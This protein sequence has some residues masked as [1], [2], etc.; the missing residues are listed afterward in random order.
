[1]RA[2]MPMWRGDSFERLLCS[3]LDVGE[4]PIAEI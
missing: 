1:V 4:R 3:E 2:S